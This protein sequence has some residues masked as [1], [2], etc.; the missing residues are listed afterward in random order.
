[1][2]VIEEIQSE[3]SRLTEQVQL[4]SEIIEGKE[5]TISARLLKKKKMLEE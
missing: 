5:E 1:M 4:L 2:K 3:N